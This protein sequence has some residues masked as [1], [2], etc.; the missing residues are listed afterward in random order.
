VFV[1]LLACCHV[2]VVVPDETAVNLPTRQL[3]RRQSDESAV[4][5]C[6]ILKVGRKNQRPNP[7]SLTLT[8]G[9]KS[10]LA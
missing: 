3:S 4:H 9:I 1:H 2:K 6:H 5:S 8:G 10:T 7:K